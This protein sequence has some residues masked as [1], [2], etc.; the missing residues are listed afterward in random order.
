MVRCRGLILLGLLALKSRRQSDAY[1]DVRFPNCKMVQ[2][3]L[4]YSEKGVSFWPVNPHIRPDQRILLRRRLLGPLM[5]G[6][7][8]WAGWIPDWPI[9]IPIYSPYA[10]TKGSE[11][12]LADPLG[13]HEVL[14]SSSHLRTSVRTW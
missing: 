4:D 6:S 9:E 14:L 11:H 13:W 3:M 1:R 7:M 5:D 10:I 12:V 8:T 2:R